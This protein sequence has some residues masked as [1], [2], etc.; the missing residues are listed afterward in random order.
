VTVS[1]RLP[2]TIRRGRNG[3]ERVRS[4]GGLVTAFDPMLRRLGGVWVGWP[5]TELRRGEHL[6]FPGDPYQIKPVKLPKRDFR[7]YYQG[8]CNSAI[9]PLFH[10]LP[11]QAAF[12]PEDWKAYERVNARFARVTAGVIGPDHLVF[13]NDYQLM[14]MPRRLRQRRPDVRMGFFLHIPFPPYDVFR[15]LP[16]AR[17][18]L[19][20]LLSCDFVG[21]HVQNYAR[22][23]MDCAKRLLKL[24][25]DRRQ[26][27]ISVEN[28]L[29]RVAALP[30]GID[31][32]QYEDLARSAKNPVFGSGLKV[33]LGV[34]RLDYTKG[35]PER[36]RAFE[37]LLETH[38]AH[39]QKVVLV[40]LAVPSR[41]EISGYRDLK[42]TIDETVGRINGRFATAT[43]TPIRY[44]YNTVPNERLAGMYREADVG[45][46]TPLRDGM[47]LVAK[48]YVACQVGDPGVLVLSHMAGAAESMSEALKINPYN[49]ED[50]SAKLHTALTMP[51]QERRE[52]MKALRQREAASDVYRWADKLIE[53]LHEAAKLNRRPRR[54]VGAA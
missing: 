26:G 5:G 13:V 45:L 8:F 52:R 49:I 28:R 51:E 4:T 47:N 1:N 9:W 34:D 46:V 37:H 11:G 16:W 24:K 12:R 10:T 3:T 40:Q 21:F 44:L 7:G 38:P 17:P 48:E 6:N 2:V 15:V 54:T 43:W 41:A 22:N 27:L 19:R 32:K 42:R 35:I 29:V 36:M 18:V 31:F 25:T 20:G 53:S 39:R 50:T 14:R 23:F 30:L 33:I